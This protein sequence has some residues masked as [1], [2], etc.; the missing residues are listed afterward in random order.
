MNKAKLHSELIELVARKFHFL[1][2]YMEE[3]T[4]FHEIDPE[5]WRDK[6]IGKAPENLPPHAVVFN[7]FKPEVDQFTAAIMHT[8]DSNT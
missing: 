6:Y 4:P 8:I 7:K 2:G 3:Q 5:G 1:Y